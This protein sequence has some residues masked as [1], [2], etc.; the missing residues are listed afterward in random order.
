MPSAHIVS[1]KYPINNFMSYHA[2]SSNFKRIIA[3]F[4][5]S[6]EPHNYED[7]VESSVI[8]GFEESKSCVWWKAEV[9][10]VFRI[11]SG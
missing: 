1:S 9:V 4:S 5:S 2:L 8:K 6:T 3:S 11:G 7:V 10:A